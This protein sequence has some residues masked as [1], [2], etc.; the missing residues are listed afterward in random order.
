MDIFE[1]QVKESLGIDGKTYNA[2]GEPLPWEQEEDKI[3]KLR[4]QYRQAK[5]DVDRKIITIRANLLKA[6]AAKRPG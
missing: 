4:Q 3:G 2:S 5:T 1:D 6:A